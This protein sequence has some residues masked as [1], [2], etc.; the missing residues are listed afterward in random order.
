MTFVILINTNINLT[1]YDISQRLNILQLTRSSSKG[2][3]KW[4]ERRD[5]SVRGIG[6]DPFLHFFFINIFAVALS[7]R[8]RSL[9]AKHVSLGRGVDIKLLCYAFRFK[10]C[11]DDWKAMFVSG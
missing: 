5:V 2:K 10:V 7:V 8:H 9:F 4:D 3:L 1:F 11:N 6:R